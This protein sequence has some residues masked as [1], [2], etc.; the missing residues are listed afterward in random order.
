LKADPQNYLIEP[1]GDHDRAAFSCGKKPLDDYIRQQASQ[2]FKRK[3]AA[4]FV[5]L[6]RDAPERVIAYYTL[7]NRELKLTQLPADIAKKAG[8]YNSLPVTLLG[9]MA[10]DSTQQ[11]KGLGDFVL[12]DTL[13]RSL[14]ATSEV[15]SFA[16]FVEA[17]DEDSLQFY[18][19]YGFIQLPENKLKLFLLMKTIE[20]L[21]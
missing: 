20:Q 9:R 14:R 21:P 15:A 2:D 18:L 10:V 17:K 1:L 19:K 7:S 16:V 11:G 4:V 12:V 3:L 6:P 5:V 8:R 13:K